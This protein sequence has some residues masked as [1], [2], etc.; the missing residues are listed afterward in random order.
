MYIAAN[1]QTEYEVQ[2]VFQKLEENTCLAGLELLYCW[3]L[4]FVN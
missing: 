3:K 2:I 1:I 4:K